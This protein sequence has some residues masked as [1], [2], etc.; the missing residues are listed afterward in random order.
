MSM[1]IQV[2]GQEQ[3]IDVLV[4]TAGGVEEDFHKCL[5]TYLGD[6]A[7]KGAE[8]RKGLNQLATF[9]A[10]RQLLQVRGLDHAHTGRDEERMRLVWWTPSKVIHRLGLRLTMRRASITGPQR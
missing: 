3:M 7:L 5:P 10:Q 4:T 2:P 6:F 1:G 9:C 8:L